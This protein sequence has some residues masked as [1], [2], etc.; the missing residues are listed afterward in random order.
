MVRQMVAVPAADRATRRDRAAAAFLFLSGIRATAFCGLTLE[1]V[2]VAQRKVY[3]M[4]SMGVR[5]KNRKSATTSLYEIEDLLVVVSEW[6][7]EMRDN[8]P[9]TALWYPVYGDNHID[10]FS[11]WRASALRDNLKTLADAA[12]VKYLSPH[13]FRH[14]NVVHGL[15]MARNMWEYKAVSQNLM[16]SNINTTV[17]IYAVLADDD[18]QFKIAELGKDAPVDDVVALVMKRLQEKQEEALLLGDRR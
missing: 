4:L 17:E 8:N 13:K 10:G 7:R 12:G 18:V 11:T 3:Q 15:K 6:Y 14:G 1:C 2:D 5:T 9:P 16:H